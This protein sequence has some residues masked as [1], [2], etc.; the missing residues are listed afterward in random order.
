MG[1]RDNW[2]DMES[3]SSSASSGG[4]ILQNDNANI[5]ASM[6]HANATILQVQGLTGNEE[7]QRPLTMKHG[8]FGHRIP[9]RFKPVS[10]LWLL[11]RGVI[12][13]LFWLKR[14]DASYNNE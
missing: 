8:I 2:L 12:M 7:G 1:R 6:G 9:R 3:Q 11:M 10:R 4:G 5:M 14:L 13:W